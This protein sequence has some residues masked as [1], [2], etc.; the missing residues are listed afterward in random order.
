M[1]SEV[2]TGISLFIATNIDDLILLIMF[3]ALYHNRQKR[4][5]I[6]VGQYMGMS[7]LIGLSLLF[8]YT[9]SQLDLFE[10][11]WL[12][13]IPIGLGIKTFFEKESVEEDLKKNQSSLVSQVMILTLLNGTDNVAVYTSLFTTLEFFSLVLYVLLFLVMTAFWCYLAINLVRNEKIRSQL[14][15]YKRILVP[16]VLVYV[17]LNMIIG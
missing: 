13:V 7:T 10:L 1:F 2:L 11:R 14:I 9:M 17:G 16:V 8:S 3:F 4:K 15:R 6:I 5:E 12:G